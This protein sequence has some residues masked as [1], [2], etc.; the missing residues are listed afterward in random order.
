M[1]FIRDV[2]NYDK[3]VQSV[4]KV[5]VYDEKKDF[6]G[7]EKTKATYD[8]AVFGVKFR[9]FMIMTFN[10]RFN[11]FTWTLDY[12]RNSDFDDNVGH[13]QVMKHP[14]K[15]GWSR[16]LYSCQVK[17]FSWVPGIV[18]NFLTKSALIEAT[19]WVK[20]ASEAEAA[21]TPS[22]TNN[23]WFTGKAK[24]ESFTN[25][26][27]DKLKQRHEQDLMFLRKESQLVKCRLQNFFG[28]PR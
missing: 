6:M 16:V 20:K 13:W 15:N 27:A 3:Y 12:S 21:K 8:V 24:V 22:K 18:V 23:P 17:L 7:I 26:L 2:R 10:P 19:T 28:C 14:S 1:K 11:T 9:Y 25:N 5:T 4:K